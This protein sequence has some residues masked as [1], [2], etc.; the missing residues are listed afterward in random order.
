MTASWRSAENGLL[1]YLQSIS[2]LRG[3]P[4]RKLHP[5]SPVELLDLLLALGKLL[6]QRADLLLETLQGDLVVLKGCR[7]VLDPDKESRTTATVTSSRPRV[8]SRYNRLAITAGCR[9]NNP[10]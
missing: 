10:E 3:A 6:A 2:R 1:V 7:H 9:A 5:L 4:A 8:K